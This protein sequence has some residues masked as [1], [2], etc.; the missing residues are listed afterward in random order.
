MSLQVI[1]QRKRGFICVNA[2]PE[3]CR[4]NIGRQVEAIRQAVPKPFEGVKNAL[5]IGLTG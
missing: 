2:H 5:I 1:K 4:R 3:G